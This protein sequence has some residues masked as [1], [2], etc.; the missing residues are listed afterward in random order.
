M[1]KTKLQIDYDFDFVLIGITTGLKGFKLA[2]E[3]NRQLDIQLVKKDD[4][5]VGFKGGT[6]KSFSMHAHQTQQR[7]YRL[8]KNKPVEADSGTY[9]LLPEHPHF[10]YVMVL[11]EAEQTF[12]KNILEAIRKISSVELAAFI[13]LA[14]LKTKE[15]FIF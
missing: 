9:F 1:K 4:L 11:H 6:E 3:L 14:S 7:T 12:A 5:L 10:D 15:N 13:P 2:W 8:V